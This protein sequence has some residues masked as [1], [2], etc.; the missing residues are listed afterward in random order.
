MEGNATF[1]AS[2][3]LAA[4]VAVLTLG[5]WFFTPHSQAAGVWTNEPAGAKVLLDCPFS[6]SIC[7]L[8][9]VYGNL[10]FST[11]SSGPISPT[12]ILD[13]V[14]EAGQGTGGGQFVY[15]FRPALGQT[16]REIYLGTFWKTNSQ[17]E[18]LVVNTNKMF[19]VRNSETDNNFMSWHGPQ[20]QPRQLIWYMQSTY[21]NCHIPSYY[22]PGCGNPSA[23]PGTGWFT[24]N[25]PSS[26]VVAAGSGWH[27]IEMH[28]K[29]STTATSQ[30]GI[31]QWW[32]DGVLVGN[33]SNV[34]LSPTGFADF[35]INHTW[36]GSTAL[37]APNR[38]MSLAW[39]HYWDHLY[40]SSSQ[41]SSAADQ[42]PGPPAQP[43]MRSVTTP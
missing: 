27:K 13:E 14:L 29:S 4:I 22:S 9:S 25:G 20:N 31:L 17:F 30:D 33:F 42:P 15:E 16:A 8:F 26:G 39:H 34:N 40:I 5:S 18:G 12:G 11:D 3:R 1:H 41:G 24:P 35:Q 23:G 2:K 21:N 28:M 36:D 37:F 43:T 7:Q 32:L 10:P 38:N 19:F 6:G